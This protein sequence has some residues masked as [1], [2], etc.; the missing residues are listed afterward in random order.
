M[1]SLH[2]VGGEKGGEGR[3]FVCRALIDYHRIQ[4]IPVSVFD[5]C[6]SYSDVSRFYQNIEGCKAKGFSHDDSLMEIA[7]DVLDEELE[8]SVIV[9]LQTYGMNQMLWPWMG[10]DKDDYLEELQRK[11]PV[12]WFVSL[13]SDDSYRLFQESLDYFQ[14]SVRHV[15]VRNFAKR[16]RW[17]REDLAEKFDFLSSEHNIPVIDFP[18]FR[19]GKALELILNEDVPYIEAWQH[20]ALSRLSR[21]QTFIFLRK[22][23]A[24]FESA[25]VIQTDFTHQ[26]EAAI[27]RIVQKMPLPN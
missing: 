23:F 26:M 7:F 9:N 17:S 15:L 25:N 2:F 8:G 12:V 18:Y 22:A 1:T 13:G 5:T 14:G 24:A 6:R 27:P 16:S 19:Y 20:P 4:N 21:K 10:E 11:N 3:S